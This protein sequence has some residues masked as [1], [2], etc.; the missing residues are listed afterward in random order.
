MI[1]DAIKASTNGELDRLWIDE[2]SVPETKERADLVSVGARLD[3]Y[4]IKTERDDLRRLPRQ[5]NAF[6]RLFDQCTI[7]TAEKHLDGCLDLV[8][9]WWAVLVAR[10]GPSGVNLFLVREGQ[11]N[12]SPDAEV[13]VR[14]LWKREVAEAV[15]EIAA[16][17]PPEASRQALWDALLKHGRPT[18][19]RK[20]VRDALYYRDGTSARM[21]SRRFNVGRAVADP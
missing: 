17:S 9:D 19:I 16:P 4:E 20:L 1:S 13:L 18:E 5:V 21:P 15:K 10:L 11:T 12:P 6:S 8:P 7:V 2:F 3:G 14:L